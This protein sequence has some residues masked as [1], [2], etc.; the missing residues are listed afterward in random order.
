MVEN[1]SQHYSQSTK[2]S[3]TY[4][5]NNIQ[6]ILLKYVNVLTQTFNNLLLYIYFKLLIKTYNILMIWF[7]PYDPYDQIRFLPYLISSITLKRELP[8]E[9][10]C[11]FPACQ[12]KKKEIFIEYLLN[13]LMD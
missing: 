3:I 12:L 6:I 11:F 4:F 5:Q 2:N 9:L 1:W 8:C 7:H 10:I 13:E